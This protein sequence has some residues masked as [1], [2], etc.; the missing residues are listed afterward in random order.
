M[1]KSEEVSFAT[2]DVK[3]Y[4]AGAGAGKTSALMEELAE[5]LKSYRPD[6]I[7]FVTFTRKGVANG[8]ERALLANPQ[9]S[10]DDLPHFKTLHAL[11]YRELGLKRTSMITQ[12]DMRFFNR[13]LGFKVHLKEDFGNQSDDDKLMSRYDALRNGSKKGAYVFGA[14][15]EAR[16][17]RLTRAYEAFKEANHLVDFHDCLSKFR[18]RGKPVAVKV[19]LIDEAQDLTLLQWEVC[20]IAFSQ[21]EKVRICG[22]DWQS[23]FAYNGASPRTL[24]SLATRYPTV[25]LEKSYRLSRQV[26]KFAK[27][28]TSFIADKIEKDFEP[29]KDV[30]GFVEDLPD[31]TMLM[32]KIH[33]DLTD[34][35]PE[36]GRWYLLFRNNYFLAPITDLLEQFCIPYHTPKGFCL[37]AK[38]LAKIRRYHNFRVWG[39]GSKES[40]AHF[41]S[42]YHIKDINADFVESGLI[43][44]ERRYVY[45]RYIEQFGL[46]KLEEMARS[47][48]YVLLSTVHRVKG[49][50]ADFVAL[51]TD[52]TR[53]VEE[54]MLLNLDE[55]LR[56]L[57][58]AC[59]RAKIGMYLCRVDWASKNS[60][61]KVVEVVREAV[62]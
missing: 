32:H 5:L 46:D 44:S 3:I 61:D 8:I 49:G 38:D 48:P 36:P 27:G 24:V 6:E 19:A 57:Y 14:Y 41:C 17:H 1:I 58:V 43:P 22:D 20:Q 39:Y 59:T 12:N 28:V 26:H 51:F 56:V 40:F 29:V 54:N 7:A 21:C 23:L 47:E 42:R 60:I 55:E 13:L 45:S 18:D 35:G 4:L 10:A 25:K 33:K 30:E 34:N 52:C 11:C 53:K 2:D 9:L 15:D 50:E 62:S 31:R 37:N 16:Y